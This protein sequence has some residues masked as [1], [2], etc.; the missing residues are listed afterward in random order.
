MSLLHADIN[1]SIEEELSEI[2]QPA[3]FKRRF[4]K[5]LENVVTGNLNDTD[6]RQV[7][8]LLTVNEEEV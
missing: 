2:D 1:A 5:L 8:E 6:V 3:E 7:V 4:R